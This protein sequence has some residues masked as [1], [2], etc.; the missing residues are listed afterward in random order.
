MKPPFLEAINF[1]EE[2]FNDENK[3]LLELRI[4]LVEKCNLK[5]IYCLSDAPFMTERKPINY[6]LTLDDIKNNI[7]EAKKLGIKTVCITGS[8]EPLLC[9][10][11]KELIEFIRSLDLKVVIF[12][13]SLLLTKNFSK[14]LYENGVNLMVKLNSFKP[15]VNDNLVGIA[16]AQ[17]IF[18]E[19]IKMLID[20]GFA[21]KHMLALNCVITNENYEE[22]QEIFTFC[23]KNNIIPWIETLT[24][25]GRATR[26]MIV[27]RNKIE[28]LY[29]KLAE[30]DKNLFGF[31]WEPDSPIVGASR[32]RYK[33]VCQIDVYGNL[34]H[35]DA[36]ITDDVGNVRNKS[37]KELV[38]SEKF[39]QL[40]D[41]D[42][43]SKHFLSDN[44]D[45]L[46]NSIYKILTSRKFRAGTIPSEKTKQLILEKIKLKV[47]KNE[48]I[49]LFQFWG[50]CKNPN[51]SI[52]YADLCEEATLDNLNR[53]NL[54]IKNTHPSGLK[55]WISPGDSRVERVNLIPHEKTLKYVRTLTTIAEQKKYNGLFTVVPL[56]TLYDKYSTRFEETLI[57][58]RGRISKDVENHKDF[59]KLIAN[60]KKN[61][62][63]KELE[64]EGKIKARSINSAR[65]YVIYRITEE[66]AN[67]FREFK[68]CI[69][70]FFI[71][72][73]PFYKQYIKETDEIIPHLDCS[74]VFFTGR[75][76]NITQ[77]WQ[78]I[79]REESGEI[80]FL[81]Q[82]RLK[83]LN[84]EFQFPKLI[85]PN[86][87]INAAGGI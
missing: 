55:I 72:Y 33:Y 78:A 5:C 80:L 81:S 26:E 46:A 62:F 56:S 36:N 24:I 58:V 27:S 77:P 12:T 39:K 8:G 30:I 21:Q 69:R 20:M 28:K 54:E 63:G 51:L 13:N 87:K 16:G 53:L 68:D 31:E 11:L 85:Y 49:E 3:I 4:H 76:G 2:D 6:K 14:F 45:E 82:E 84:V 57:K 65:D 10:N 42:K 61:V 43:H 19:K 40:R 70:S 17:K 44:L 50:G 59:G 48:P 52:D 23:R 64:S 38:L 83:I 7:I 74:L 35:T 47:S 25:T 79:S 34:Y 75:K 66:E 1:T 18:L 22:I 15:E 67:I 73:I 37:I 32:R 60:A 9:D 29:R 41:G 71:K 86:K